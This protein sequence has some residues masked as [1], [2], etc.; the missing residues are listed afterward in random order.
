LLQ[1]YH[2]SIA[3]IHE[4]LD[5]GLSGTGT[6]VPDVAVPNV[7]PTSILRTLEMGIGAVKAPVSY[8]VAKP[9]L[10]PSG[11]IFIG[12]LGIV[13]P[14]FAAV[15]PRQLHL[16]LLLLPGDNAFSYLIETGSFLGR[17]YSTRMLP[18]TSRKVEVG[19]T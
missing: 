8:L 9:A 10:L 5:L 15:L 19:L 1:I 6:H 16:R 7:D 11:A 2:L 3:R 14:T 13:H 12:M 18:L 17:L 4:V